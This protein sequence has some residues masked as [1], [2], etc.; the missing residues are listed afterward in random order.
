[1]A[2]QALALG[3]VQQ[4]L[5]GLVQCLPQQLH[6]FTIIIIIRIK[7]PITNHYFLNILKVIGNN[8]ENN[9]YYNLKMGQNS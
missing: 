4:D 2:L 8:L 5:V 7:I 9:D 6:T 1:M 3:L